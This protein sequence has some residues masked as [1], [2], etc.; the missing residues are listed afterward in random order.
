MMIYQKHFDDYSQ[1]NTI[2]QNK[3]IEIFPMFFNKYEYEDASNNY[4]Y[5]N[6]RLSHS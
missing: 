3:N 2:R 5:G 6:H 1:T 4:S